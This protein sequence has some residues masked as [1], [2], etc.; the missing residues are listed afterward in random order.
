VTNRI[1]SAF[2][3][4]CTVRR[5]GLYM[6]KNVAFRRNVVI[7]IREDFHLES[8]LERDYPHWG[9][10]WFSLSLVRYFAGLRS[11]SARI[12]DSHNKLT[13]PPKRDSNGLVSIWAAFTAPGSTFFRDGGANFI[14]LHLVSVT[15][16]IIVLPSELQ[17]SHVVS[18]ILLQLLT[19]ATCRPFPPLGH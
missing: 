15:V 8:P 19:Q 9:S 1:T 17:I 7:I 18:S 13:L 5:I 6:S 2:T 11:H 4:Q 3:W 10:P 16:I 14:P 12:A